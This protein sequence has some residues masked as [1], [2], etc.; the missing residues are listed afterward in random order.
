MLPENK[1]CSHP[2]GIPDDEGR[3]GGPEP[4]ILPALDHSCNL[5]YLT[6]RKAW[7]NRI[8]WGDV[9]RFPQVWLAK[10]KVTI[11]QQQ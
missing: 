8:S 2:W 10:P 5:I 6:K 11:P 1:V 3:D 7:N 9:G 4:N